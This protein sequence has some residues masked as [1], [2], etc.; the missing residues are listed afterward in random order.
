MAGTQTGS[1]RISVCMTAMNKSPA[2]TPLKMDI[3]RP[4]K[5]GNI[6]WNSSSISPAARDVVTSGLDVCDIY[7]RY[8]TTS[9]NTKLR[10]VELLHLENMGTA[11]GILLLY[12]VELVVEV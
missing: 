10:T 1:Y 4:W 6:H 8:K 9:Y 11:V 7:F 5:F 12:A 3:Q 2:A